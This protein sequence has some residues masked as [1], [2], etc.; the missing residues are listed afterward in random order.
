MH[1]AHANNPGLMYNINNAEATVISHSRRG[2]DPP[3]A[4]LH[5]GKLL[6]QDLVFLRRT[7]FSLGMVNKQ[8]GHV[9]QSCHPADN[10][11]NM[12]CFCV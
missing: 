12:D 10:E 6:M 7:I 9:K 3:E 11:N 2:D 4:V 8:A 5:Q 1:P